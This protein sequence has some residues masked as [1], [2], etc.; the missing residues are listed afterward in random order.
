MELRISGW[1]SFREGK[2]MYY[3]IILQVFIKKLLNG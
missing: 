3:K 2:N 1:D